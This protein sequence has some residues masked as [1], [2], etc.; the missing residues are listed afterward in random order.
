MWSVWRI[1]RRKG[2]GERVGGAWRE[3][4]GK[5]IDVSEM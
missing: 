4:V 5:K 1:R 2:V 3:L